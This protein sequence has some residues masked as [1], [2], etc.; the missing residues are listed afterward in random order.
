MKDRGGKGIH[1]ES[2][3][4]QEN[5]YKKI[6]SKNDN[7]DI[8]NSCVDSS[9]YLRSCYKDGEEKHLPRQSLVPDF[10]MNIYIEALFK[11]VRE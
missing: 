8:Y 11:C 6:T 7:K 4:L 10:I 9:K 5:D 2:I 3:N 1:Y